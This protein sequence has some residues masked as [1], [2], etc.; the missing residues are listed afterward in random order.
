MRKVKFNLGIDMILLIA[1]V[2]GYFVFH[3]DS[4]IHWLLVLALVHILL[5]ILAN[6]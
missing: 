3:A 6:Y 5:D 4:F 2:L 1:W